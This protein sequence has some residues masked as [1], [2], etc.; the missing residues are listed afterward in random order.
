MHMDT[1]IQWCLDKVR[2]GCKTD[3]KTAEYLEPAMKLTSSRRKTCLIMVSF[4]AVYL[5]Q[6]EFVWCSVGRYAYMVNSLI[7]LEMAPKPA[8]VAA[9]H[10]TWT[11]KD[12]DKQ[13]TLNYWKEVTHRI[14]T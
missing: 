9:L 1:N 14:R 5:D 4:D 10:W 8:Q 2:D 12:A 6:S 13:G 7:H 3:I 11:K